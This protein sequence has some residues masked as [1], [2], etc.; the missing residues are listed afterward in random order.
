M[1]QQRCLCTCSH[2]CDVTFLCLHIF[3]RAQRAILAELRQNIPLRY[4]FLFSENHVEIISGKQEGVYGWLATNYLLGRFGHPEKHHLQ[5]E[6]AAHAAEQ[7][8]TEE[9]VPMVAVPHQPESRSV[10]DVKS[11]SGDGSSESRAHVHMRPRTVGVID[12]GGASFQVAVEVSRDLAASLPDDLVAQFNLGCTR[13]DAMHTYAIYVTTFLGYGANA[14]RRHYEQMLAKSAQSSST[15]P[16]QAFR[17]TKAQN[18]SI[19]VFGHRN[20]STMLRPAIALR[21]GRLR[22][23]LSAP[24][25]VPPVALDPCLPAGL[26][27]RSAATGQ[28]LVGRGNLRTCLKSV[29]PLLNISAPCPLQPCSL[30]GRHQPQVDF[31]RQEFYGFSEYWYTTAQVLHMGGH[32]DYHKFYRAAADYCSSS[33]IAIKTKFRAKLFPE[34]DSERMRCLADFLS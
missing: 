20:S 22:R 9:R 28:R 1:L 29:L 3:G 19:S 18:K 11:G 31:V 24:A 25:S 8:R 4:K 17:S 21:S 32:Y 12:M 14:A 6:V 16:T 15:L 7:W 26:T 2:V 23:H 5:K 30:A 33:W 10:N 34:A 13:G 27:V